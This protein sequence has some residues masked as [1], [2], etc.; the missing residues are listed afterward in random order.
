M[1]NREVGKTERMRGTGKT[2]RMLRW[3]IA[4]A[5]AGS[6]VLIYSA[7]ARQK[8]QLA[9]RIM[10]GWTDVVLPATPNLG[11]IYFHPPKAG[12]R[13]GVNGSITIQVMGPISEAPDPPMGRIYDEVAIDHFAREVRLDRLSS[14]YAS[15]ASINTQPE[16]DA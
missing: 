4:Q 6:N 7:T 1:I 15:W 3:A 12:P 9:Q 5:Q 14:L 2:E 16:L 8:V 13:R 10:H 11:T